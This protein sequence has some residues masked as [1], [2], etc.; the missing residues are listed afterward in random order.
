MTTAGDSYVAPSG[1]DEDDND[2]AMVETSVEYDLALVK[3]AA[4]TPVTQTDDATVTYTITVQNQ[5]TVDSGP[6]AVTDVVPAG[7]T[8][9]DAGSGTTTANPDGSTTIELE[10]ANLGPDDVATFTI[11]T[12]VTDLTER[13]YRNVA[14]ISG[15]SAAALY[16]L[17]DVDSTPDADPGND[18]DYGPVGEPSDIDN[19]TI[20][21]AGVGPD[22]PPAGEDDADIADVSFPLT[23]DLALAKVADAAIVELDETIGYTITVQNQGVLESLAYTVTDQVPAGLEVVPGSI[24]SGGVLTGDP[25]TGSVITWSLE[26][27]APAASVELTFDA[28]VDDVTLRPFRNQA[29][30][31][32]DSADSW[33]VPDD[34]I[35]DIDS[36]PDTDAGNDGD[37]GPIG[38][39]SDLD[40]QAITDAGVGPDAPPAGEDDADIADVDVDVRYDLALVKTGPADVA[41]DPLP[42]PVTYTIVVQ[43][44][45][46]VPSGAYSVTDDVPR[47]MT[48]TDAS[49]DGQIGP[50]GATVTW[51]DLP[52]L[53]PGDSAVLTLGLQIDDLTTRPWTN[54]AGITADSAG[55]YSSATETVTDIDSVPG[56]P[57]TSAIDN[58]VIDEA[59]LGDDEGFDDE[60]IAVTTTTIVYDLAL[61]KTV[62]D[63]VVA[64]GAENLFTITVQNQ[65]N[66]PSG[67][68]SVTDD[69]PGGLSV[70][71]GSVDDGGVAS[72][73]PLGPA[74]TVT[75]ADLPSLAPG[76]TA[77]LTFRVTISDEGEGRP[78]INF[79]EITADS[80]GDYTSIDQEVDPDV[81]GP[82]AADVVTDVD[83]VPGDPETSLVN[84][85]TIA[86][87]GQGL[88]AGFDDE[89]IAVILAPVEYDL[90]LVKTVDK[91]TI[92]YAD[93]A[94]FTITVENQGNVP[95]RSYSVADD[96][97]DGLAVVT[98]SVSDGGVV[99]DDGTR[100]D[101]TDLPSID[102]GASAVLTFDV[103]IDDITTRPW[104]NV[105]EIV[106]DS[107]DTYTVID[108]LPVTDRDSTPGDP[109]TSS[110]DN[111]AI[112]QAGLGEDEGF[113][114]EDIAFLD[115]PVTY[116]LAID[117]RLL[118]D[119][120]YV[121]GD[122]VT[123]E[124]EVTNQGNVPSELYSFTDTIPPGMAFESASDGGTADGQVV[125]WSDMASLDPGASKIVTV[126]STLTDVTLGSYRNWV[127]VTADSAD[128]YSTAD[129]AVVDV[130][131]TPGNGEM[132]E[133]DDDFA[134]IPVSDVQADN[135]AAA[136]GTM[137]VTG[138]DPSLPL[139][140]GLFLLL[141]GAA[142]VAAHRARWHLRRGRPSGR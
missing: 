10:G 30:I 113:D 95:S 58:S 51:V 9:D 47:G 97:P 111:T 44:Q 124:V 90:A 121:L 116:D 80:A 62:D 86:D 72:D 74:S 23:Y 16:G 132:G 39:P 46:N 56:D 42:A 135:A 125:T 32:A 14:E 84:S 133:D 25:V 91:P 104:T 92:G 15:D 100:I 12:T 88:D 107:A 118:P 71:A 85:V 27:L 7:L 108:L 123:Y 64:P 67:A 29:E 52:S 98:S 142:V 89:D 34:P 65:G 94:T 69:V 63:V 21:E 66:V 13:P 126:A 103:T 22:A 45:G 28:T 31:T 114:D 26:G 115:S 40:N 2:T 106:A 83:S 53:D 141:V 101:W 36:T 59:G 1:S 35:V 70:V 117:K 102:A 6:Y 122:V 81:I 33:S 43:N 127:Q 19:L 11:A 3:T 112:D 131:S 79:A 87:A 99:S 8:V 73:L 76:E 75:W 50:F 134:E 61:V 57:E 54:A 24:S 82:L 60:D 4:A 49:D 128:G 5:G 37:Y 105:A 77:D 137:P 110:V 140:L 17:T 68:Y 96:V 119:Q 93:T 38:D 78:Y 20:D 129:R 130:D 48:A 109:D 138:G 120:T 55:S 41:P 139:R 136:A 18:G